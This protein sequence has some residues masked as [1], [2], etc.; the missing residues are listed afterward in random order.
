MLLNSQSLGMDYLTWQMSVLFW[1]SCL[2]SE[3]QVAVPNKIALQTQKPQ[4][5]KQS[6]CRQMT[7][8]SAT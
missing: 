8:L 5:L 3:W 2:L 7:A 6:K 4:P 1:R